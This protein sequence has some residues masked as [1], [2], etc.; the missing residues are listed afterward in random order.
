MNGRLQFMNSPLIRN[1]FGRYNH[2]HHHHR[3]RHRLDSDQLP[4]CVQFDES[5]DSYRC[6]CGCF[7]IK[8]GGFVISGV[9]LF[10]VFFYFLN[11]LLIMLQQK[12]NYEYDKGDRSS[13]YV[14]VAFIIIAVASGIALFTIFLT[15]VGLTRNIAAC[16]VP[17]LIVQGIS[18]LCF[19]GLIVVGIIALITNSSF[20]YRLLNA[21]PFNDF[22][23]Q[24]TVALP[25]E[26]QVRVYGVL[27]MYTLSFFLECW[28]I[29]INYNCNRYFTERKT[30][31][32]YCLAYSTPLKTLNSAR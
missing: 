4:K 6:F 2:Q 10:F 30:Y 8:T 20:F 22:P 21:T 28:F 29:V 9:E 27:V 25:V 5:S 14:Y 23:G 11:S 13:D 16:L 1:T 17:H 31:M 7:H 26:S 12:N 24:M 19:L 15:L 18:I 32:N 3:P